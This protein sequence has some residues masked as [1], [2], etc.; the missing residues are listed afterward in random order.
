MTVSRAHREKVTVGW[1]ALA[2]VIG[3]DGQ[4]RPVIQSRIFHAKEAA[5]DFV[6]L[7]RSQGADEPYIAPVE[8]FERKEADIS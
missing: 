6:E 7:L 3:E 1:R 8:R 5:V 2:F 4:R